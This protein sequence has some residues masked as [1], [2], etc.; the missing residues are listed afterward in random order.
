MEEYLNLLLE[1]IRYQKARPVI[2]EEL[3]SH[4]EEQIEANLAAGM[5]AMEAQKEAVRDM[6]SP[7]EAG[8]A[9]DKIHRP[10]NAWGMIGFMAALT[11]T[12]IV[13]QSMLGTHGFARYAVLSFVVMLAVCYFDYTLI[14]RFAKITAGAF[15]VLCI[16]G[17]CQRNYVNGMSYCIRLGF[18]NVSLFSFMMLYVPLY[19]AVLY[20]CSRDHKEKM[21]LSKETDGKFQMLY[22]KY[23]D[24]VKAFFW[25]AFPVW[26]AL[27]IPSISLAFMLLLSMSIL[28]TIVLC[29]GWFDLKARRIV[30]ALWSVILLVPAALLGIFWRSLPVYQTD[31]LKAFVTGG[32]SANYLTNVLRECVKNG[33][34]FGG[35]RQELSQKLPDLNSGFLYTYLSSGYGMILGIAL[36]TV[37]AALL[38]RTFVICLKLKNRLGMIMGLGSVLIL[39]INVMINILENMGLFPLSQTFLPFFSAG[40][41]CI[42]VCY[43][44]M[45]II[46]SVYRYK[47]VY[48]VHVHTKRPKIRMTID[49]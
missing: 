38:I 10:K 36:C 47:N 49:L 11:I 26:I 44:L 34:L 4:M 16:F 39:G 32:G 28:L 30:A 31:R 27:R 24:L 29:K 48:S 18:L 13:I 33:R 22:R 9:L 5:S 7:K 20:Q 1:Q 14:G 46:L 19:G 15:C 21:L 17:I 35:E 45:G 25:M 8:I 40:G 41:S 2:R 37:L 23:K 3:Q 12:A 6:G 43:T 42:L